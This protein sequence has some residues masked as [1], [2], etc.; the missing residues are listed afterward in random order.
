MNKNVGGSEDWFLAAAVVAALLGAVAIA[1]HVPATWPLAL[2]AAGTCAA[3]A[4]FLVRGLRS[5]IGVRAVLL[6]LFGVS[7]VLSAVWFPL[8]VPA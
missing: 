8:L 4:L 2:G 7:L 6:F 1:K 5:S 3:S